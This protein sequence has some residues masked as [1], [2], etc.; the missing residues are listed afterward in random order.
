M[1]SGA[2][3]SGFFRG[4]LEDGGEAGLLGDF[5][6]QPISTTQSPTSPNGV[7]KDNRAAGGRLEFSPEKVPKSIG[8]LSCRHKKY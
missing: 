1:E 3:I 7:A 6:P 4:G 8:S 5:S 2:R